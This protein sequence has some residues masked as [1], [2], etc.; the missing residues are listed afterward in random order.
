[1]L[2][3]VRWRWSERRRH[4]ARLVRE[5][6]VEQRGHALRIDAHGADA[7]IN[8]VLVGRWGHLVPS[9]QVVDECEVLLGHETTQLARVQTPL[10][11]ARELLRNEQI[12]T[13][14]LALHFLLDPR[15]VDVELLGTVRDGAEHAA[16][17]GVRDGRNDIAAVAEAEERKVDAD[18]VSRSRAHL[19]SFHHAARFFPCEPYACRSTSVPVRR[20]SCCR[21]SRSRRRSIARPPRSSPSTV[22]SS[23]PTCTESTRRGGTTR[24]CSGSVPRS[25]SSSSTGSRSS[26]IPSPAA[27]SSGSPP[28]IPS[29]SSSSSSW[30]RSPCRA[31]CRS[32]KR[33]CVIPP[34]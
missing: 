10:V 1:M 12:H 27:W 19:G 33:H 34:A 20:S 28:V 15:E 31:R 16:P 18:Q 32:P 24:S 11:G 7:P 5:Q 17:A 3:E 25:I 23:C 21:G 8:R 13:V 29:A 30:T 22:E 4:Q 9:E 6:H 2:D 14:R 26:G